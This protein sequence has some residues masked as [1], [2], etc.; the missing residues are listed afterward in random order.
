MKKFNL[1]LILV[2]LLISTPITTKAQTNPNTHAIKL[3]HKLIKQKHF[4]G[5]I[6]LVK[7]GQI[8]AQISNGYQNYQ[9]KVKNTA[10]TP[11]MIGSVSKAI[12]AQLI[13]LLA[14]NKK[15]ALTDR[16]ATYYPNL[17]GASKVTLAELLNHRSGLDTSYFSLHKHY[18]SYQTYLIALVHQ[19]KIDPQNIN[20]WHYSSYNYNLLAG[21]ITQ[22]SGQSYATFLKQAITTPLGIHLDLMQATALKSYSYLRGG[23][24]SQTDYNPYNAY[25][26]GQIAMNGRDLYYL[27]AAFLQ[28]KLLT[29]SLT[30]TL[31]H[32]PPTA[33]FPYYSAGFYH[34]Q[35]GVYHLH[36]TQLGDETSVTISPDGQQA[37]L[38]QSNVTA[39]TKGGVNYTFD[40]PLFAALNK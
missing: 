23:F 28:S 15:L 26:A 1:M 13:A 40:L 19:A 5:T 39:Y 25:G 36:G 31:Y 33:A 34:L 11:Y 6:T 12:T 32:K 30:A 35:S 8:I 24:F 18:S 37:V 10:T 29:P 14:Q 9:T 3:A 27:L 16:L 7:N 2:A 4:A 21:I 22:V 20:S 38:V 17:P